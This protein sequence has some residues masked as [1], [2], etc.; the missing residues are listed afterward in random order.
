MPLELTIASLCKP[1]PS[2]THK[3]AALRVSRLSTQAALGFD[4][5]VKRSPRR[6]TM[7]I[8][9]RRGDVH[10]MLPHF[11]SDQEGMRFLQQK[12]Q[13]VTQT[14]KK[15]RQH[16]EEI[17]IK[18]YVEGETFHFLG[19]AYPLQIVIAKRSEVQLIN[20]SLIVAIVKRAGLSTAA[21]VQKALW[22][23]YQS[24]ARQLLTAKTDAL[25]KRIGRSYAGVR[26]RRTKTKWGHCTSKGIIQY[27]WQIVAAPESVIDYLVAHEI[28]HLVHPNHSKRFWRHV[29]HLLPDY[30]AQRH[31]LKTRGHTLVM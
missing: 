27:N 6:R 16:A 4:V 28:S 12:R 26:L 3:P 14:L 19:E 30:K 1:M 13:W 17:R 31:W 7:E 24:Q 20:G 9:I 11:I 8:I 10:L 15:Q 5:T 22:Q 2:R 18:Q 29:E 25:A 23:W 21:T